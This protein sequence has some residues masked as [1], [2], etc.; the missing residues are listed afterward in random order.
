MSDQSTP[1]TPREFSAIIADRETATKALEA[2]TADGAKA[3]KADLEAAQSNLDGINAELEAAKAAT[4]Q[5]A[6]NAKQAEYRTATTAGVKAAL[7]RDMNRIRKA[8]GL[9]EL[10]AGSKS[11][12]PR[13]DAATLAILEQI[14][15]DES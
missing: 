10:I 13:F 7:R 12:G 8:Q 15:G 9:P 2:L 14:E 5:A 1:A 6:Y 3:T 4:L 11:S